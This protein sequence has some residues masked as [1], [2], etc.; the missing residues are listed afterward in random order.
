MNIR[1]TSEVSLSR[2][3]SLSTSM[4]RR[5]CIKN[6]TEYESGETRGILLALAAGDAYWEMDG[7]MVMVEERLCRMADQSA[8]STAVISKRVGGLFSTGGGLPR[9]GCWVFR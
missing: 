1:V 5:S 6:C 3:A 4:L 2:G 7:G 8:M 9:S